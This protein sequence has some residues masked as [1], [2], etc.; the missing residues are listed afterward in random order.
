MCLNFIA[1]IFAML[2]AALG[3]C[4]KLFMQHRQVESCV[5]CA[6]SATRNAWKLVLD[7]SWRGAVSGAACC[8]HWLLVHP[9]SLFVNFIR[10]VEN[11]NINL[12]FC[13]VRIVHSRRATVPQQHHS[14]HS[15]GHNFKLTPKTCLGV[16]R[17]I[18]FGR[19]NVQRQ[20]HESYCCCCCCCGGGGKRE[21]VAMHLP[22]MQRN[23]CQS[24]DA[25]HSHTTPHH[26]A[27]NCINT[28]V[29]W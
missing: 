5:I 17:T 12:V 28:T 1:N 25:T 15:D 13:F 20:R 10:K 16:F 3:R 7:E 27:G 19:V 18:A 6:Q 11:V 4:G 29:G 23:E 8:W 9:Q 2:P 24:I 22:Q 26:L 21:G 14:R